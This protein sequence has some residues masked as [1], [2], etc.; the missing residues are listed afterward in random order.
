MSG[1]S[2]TPLVKKLGY[3]PQESV[4]LFEA[5]DWFQ[6]ELKRAKVSPVE[7]LP[8]AWAHAFFNSQTELVR[9]LKDHDLDTIIKGLWVSWPKKSSGV[10]TDLTEQ[11]FR[12]LILPLNWVDTKVA[13][14]DDT[15]SGLKFLRR[16]N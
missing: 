8:A 14:I 16:R 10:Q 1:Y 13:A 5:P 6:L 7:T 2:E 11:T 15:W 9:W 4:A 3:A 12:D